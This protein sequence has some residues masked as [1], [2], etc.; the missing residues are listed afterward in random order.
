M[1]CDYDG[2]NLTLHTANTERLRISGTGQIGMGS[3]GQVTAL[4]GNSLYGN[5]LFRNQI[6]TQK[7]FV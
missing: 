3:S 1:F 4:N 6:L 5:N 7:Q 2:D